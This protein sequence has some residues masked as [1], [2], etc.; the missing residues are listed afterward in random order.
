MVKSTLSLTVLIN[1]QQIYHYFHHA[2]LHPI[3]ASHTD[4]SP[5]AGHARLGV[6]SSEGLRILAVSA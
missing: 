3:K 5:K 1:F 6:I 2:T 4:T